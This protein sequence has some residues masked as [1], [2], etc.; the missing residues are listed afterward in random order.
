MDFKQKLLFQT[1]EENIEKNNLHKTEEASAILFKDKSLSK[2]ARKRL[3]KSFIILAALSSDTDAI[4]NLEYARSISPKDSKLINRE[5]KILEE[6]FSLYKND[7]VENDL[8][9]FS[10]I[11]TLLIDPYKK[12]KTNF[13]S[14][15][16]KI[17]IEI[18]KKI[19]ELLPKASKEVESKY[20]YRLEQILNSLD[21][22]LSDDQRI[23]K[24][25]EI[26]APH[27]IEILKKKITKKNSKK[28]D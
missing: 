2:N 27:I 8:F 5:F 21:P 10:T 6:I 7:F 1:L 11:I 24:A 18:R 16:I 25:A 23:K 22:G 9:V 19:K 4:K 17:E 26:L 14:P 12:E 15:S 13:F 28:K 20:S 3:K